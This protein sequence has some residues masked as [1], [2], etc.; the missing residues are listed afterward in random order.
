MSTAFSMRSEVFLLHF[1]RLN[2]CPCSEMTV[3]CHWICVM[4]DVTCFSLFY[5][6]GVRIVRKFKSDDSIFKFRGCISHF[7]AVK[8]ESELSSCWD[9]D[10]A[11]NQDILLIER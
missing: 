5:Q 8:L 9:E 4:K 7:Y 10:F 6:F 2:V 1:L 3:F 11:S